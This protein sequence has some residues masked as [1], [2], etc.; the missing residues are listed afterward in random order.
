MKEDFKASNNMA[1]RLRTW[2]KSGGHLTEDRDGRARGVVRAISTS[3][4]NCMA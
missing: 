3:A 2:S 1:G 4:R